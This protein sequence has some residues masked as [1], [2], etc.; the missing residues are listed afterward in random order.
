MKAH[1][2]QNKVTTIMTLPNN[3]NS[4]L[5]KVAKKFPTYNDKL[6]LCGLCKMN[7]RTVN[8][9]LMGQG[10]KVALAEKIIMEAEKLE[11]KTA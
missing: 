11:L 4:K 5:I 8:R 9:Y 7:P 10:T 1:L 3:I 6:L 2:P